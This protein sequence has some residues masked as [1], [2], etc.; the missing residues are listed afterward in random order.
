GI[1][2]SIVRTQID[3][4]TATGDQSRDGRH[5]RPVWQRAERELRT[6][7]HLLGSQVFAVE[8]KPPIQRGVN[9]LNV[10][11]SFLATGERVD[12]RLR[13]IEQNA[14]QFQSRVTGGSKNGNVNHDWRGFL[15]VAGAGL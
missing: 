8:I 15:S 4:S 9:R 11:V 3:N 2:Q 1:A 10:R 13:V 6:L 7:G 12:F 14:N 5:A